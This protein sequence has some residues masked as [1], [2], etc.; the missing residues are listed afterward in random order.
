MRWHGVTEPESDSL[1]KSAKWKGDVRPGLVT[2]QRRTKVRLWEILLFIINKY[3]YRSRPADVLAGG[4]WWDDT[5]AL[6]SQSIT[7][8]LLDFS[9]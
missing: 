7:E 8:V 4:S 2:P 1:V 6:F 3:S 9:L 5:R